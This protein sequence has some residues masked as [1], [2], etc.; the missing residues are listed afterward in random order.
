MTSIAEKALTTFR[1][2]YS[3]EPEFVVQAPGRVNLIGEHTDYNAGF[4]FPAAIDRW[5]AF[6]ARRREDGLAVI[7]SVAH[8]E[9][10][11]FK[12]NETP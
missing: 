5:L 3:G 1:A 7:H 6:A 10:T 11:S 9:K 4:V 8:D 2:E 12:V